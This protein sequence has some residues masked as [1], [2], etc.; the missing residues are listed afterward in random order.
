MYTNRLLISFKTPSFNTFNNY[1]SVASKEK[2]HKSNKKDRPSHS[3]Y[4]LVIRSCLS[5]FIR[6]ALFSLSIE[7][8]PRD[9][10]SFV[11]GK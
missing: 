10:M 7:T 1:F 5:P 4:L 2:P 3:R 6:T 9:K 8:H 11:P